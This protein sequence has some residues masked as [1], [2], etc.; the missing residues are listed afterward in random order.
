MTDLLTSRLLYF[1]LAKTESSKPK[2]WAFRP[3]AQATL[4]QQSTIAPAKNPSIPLHEKPYSIQH[5][6]PLFTYQPPIAFGRFSSMH[7]P[8]LPPYLIRE[9][10]K[11]RLERGKEYRAIL[12]YAKEKLPSVGTLKQ[13]EDGLIYLDLDD[14]FI[15]SLFPL[16]EEECIE[17]PPF[18][19]GRE[20]LGAHIGAILPTESNNMLKTFFQELGQA[21]TFTI[22]GYYATTPESW[23]GVEKV[24]FLSLSCPELELLREKYRLPS[25]I[26]GNDFTIP[27]AIRRKTSFSSQTKEEGFFRIHVGYHPV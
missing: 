5:K 13:T 12:H 8:S 18:F 27:L 10:K 25:K 17:K 2:R 16:I 21:F 1:P 24:W 7:P 11:E 3:A 23:K 19:F 4:F 20:T 15:H 9:R 6:T 22:K 14:A 26:G